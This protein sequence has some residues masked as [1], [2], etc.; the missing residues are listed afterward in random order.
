M[1]LA[2]SLPQIVAEFLGLPVGADPG[3][4]GHLSARGSWH[5][6]RPFLFG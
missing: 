6:E 5:F 4:N 3:Q 1:L 2:P